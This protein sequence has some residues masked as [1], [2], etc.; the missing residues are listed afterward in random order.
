MADATSDV[1]NIELNGKTVACKKGMT[2]MQVA[3]KENVSIPHF[4]WHPGLSI[5]G[6]C[7]FC[8]VEVEGRPKLEIACNLQ[9][10][11][12][13][14]IRTDSSKSKEAHKWA[15][16]FHLINHPLDCPICDQ[17]GE[18]E[19][20]NYYMEVG[21]YDSEMTRPKVL[22]PK[23][24]EVGGD[25][26][27]DTERCILCSRCVRFEA[28]VTK[29]DAL[30]IFER[31]D[32]S[33][34][35]TYPDKKIEHN[36]TDN[37]VD[38]CPVGAFTSKDFRFKQR[39]WFLK[40]KAT[41]CPGCSTGCQVDVHAKPQAKRYF[42]LKPRSSEINGEWMC[43]VGRKTYKHLNKENRLIFPKVNGKATTVDA[44][45]DAL[46]AEL[47][48]TKADNWALLVT[49][50]YTT[51]EY[52]ALFQFATN[53]LGIKKVYQWR[54]SKEKIDDF[55]GILYRGDHNANT[56]GLL[57]VAKK[58]NLNWTAKDQFDMLAQS[59]ATNVIVVCPE[60]PSSFPDLEAQLKGL[61]ELKYVSFWSVTNVVEKFSA[62]HMLPLKGFA[63]KKGSFINYANKT[64]ELLESFESPTAYARDIVEVVSVLKQKWMA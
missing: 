41:T 43:D 51:Q 62:P 25:L 52:E 11:E 14:K 26:V 42:R 33:I 44:A 21:K 2:V 39:V 19:L 37:L 48:A 7:R 1:V 12:G 54:Q 28:E 57:Q 34:I 23:A 47:K 64:T 29:T 58:Y 46:V 6:V 45:T 20:Q 15:L 16:E 24:L 13:M 17:A 63:E 36:Y 30:G 55:D 56:N 50:Q 35:G 31:G 53:D 61:S 9:V 18:C 49:P 3:K 60:I 40:E 10:A 38:I 4:C 22:K 8:M 27:L 59:G 5:A 32:R